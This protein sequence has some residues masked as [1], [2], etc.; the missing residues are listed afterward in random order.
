MDEK[1][2]TAT[3]TKRSATASDTMNKFVTDLNF[4]E[5][6]TA[7][8][9]RQFPT[10]TITLM[11]ARMDNERSK[12]GSPQL[13]FFK[14]SAHSDAFIT[15]ALY[16]PILSLTLSL[17]QT[18]SLDAAGRNQYRDESPFSGKLVVRV[19]KLASRQDFITLIGK[20]WNNL[21]NK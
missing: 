5:Q 14:R 4:E 7:A 19:E 20:T 21:I 15:L 13:T 6:K 18:L 17:T 9:T 3:P 1:G 16:H 11:R 2:N 12:C 8:I 10:I